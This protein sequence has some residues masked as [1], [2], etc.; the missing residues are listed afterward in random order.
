MN[1]DLGESELSVAITAKSTLPAVD[2]VDVAEAGT[3]TKQ[4]NNLARVSTS[5]NAINLKRLS[6]LSASIT[7]DVDN[8]TGEAS[9][10]ELLETLKLL[11]KCILANARLSRACHVEEREAKEQHDA[12]SAHRS[13]YYHEWKQ[14][15]LILDRY[16]QCLTQFDKF[17]VSYLY[18]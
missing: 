1:Q 14:A 17:S 8:N 11:N 16:V 9:P 10:I 12:K 6:V 5:D 4:T 13:L 18:N 15:S 2:I 3:S 7:N